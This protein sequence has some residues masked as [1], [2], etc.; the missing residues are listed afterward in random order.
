MKLL[1]NFLQEMRKYNRK[2]EE[3]LY[4]EQEFRL[5]KEQEHQLVRCKSASCV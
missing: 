1:N 2:E 4:I 3:A 5:A